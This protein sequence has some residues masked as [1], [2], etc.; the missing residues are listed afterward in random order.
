MER[1]TEIDGFALCASPFAAPAILMLFGLASAFG[2]S[3]ASLFA[4]LF[5]QVALAFEYAPLYLAISLPLAWVLWRFFPAL[6][7]SQ[8]PIVTPLLIAGVVFALSANARAFDIRMVGPFEPESFSFVVG[9]ALNAFTFVWLH[10]RA[11]TN[12]SRRDRP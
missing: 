6:C 12:R 4:L 7:F 9:V 1:P 5:W 11:L 2:S 10:R 8:R 3:K